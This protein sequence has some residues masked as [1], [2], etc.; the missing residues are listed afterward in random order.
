MLESQNPLKPSLLTKVILPFA[1]FLSLPLLAVAQTTGGLRGQ[2][3]DPSGAVVP[4]ATVTLTQGA[5][6]LTAPSDNDGNYSFRDVPAGSYSLTID[7]QG[8]TFPKTD[9]S[10]SG[11]VRQMNLTLA[12]AVE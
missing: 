1:L 3:L 9:V 4:G 2:V 6:V 7:A 8:F 11:H 12:I 10:I 5:T